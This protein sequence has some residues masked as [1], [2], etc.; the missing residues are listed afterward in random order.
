[1][2]SLTRMRLL[3]SI[4]KLAAP[5]GLLLGLGVGCR[6]A[7]E[8]TAAPSSTN[9]A[10][11]E[12][13]SSAPSFLARVGDELITESD[14]LTEFKRRLASGRPAGTASNALQEVIQRAALLQR[15]WESDVA[16]R[17][18]VLREMDN[19]LLS[20]WMD[21]TLHAE[22][23]ALAPTDADLRQAYE[24]NMGALSQPAQIRLAW[25]QRKTERSSSEET[26]ASLRSELEKARAEFLA[27]AQTRPDALRTQGFGPLA[28]DVSEDA[29]S[30]YRGGDLGWMD[31]AHPPARIPAPVIAAALALEVSGV[32]PVLE[33]EAGVYVA[34]KIDARPAQVPRYE[35]SLPGLRRRLLRAREEALEADFRSRAVQGRR[36]EID[37]ARLAALTPPAAMPAARPPSSPGPLAPPPSTA[38]SPR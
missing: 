35:D 32:T 26:R 28:A 36:V 22:K 9:A 34:A 7:P 30:R 21:E 15:A 8:P 29:A 4:L 5:V 33:D 6:K 23:A 17:P 24:A 1:M 38:A 11:V 3:S 12:T 16:L 2:D 18:D 37:Q 14:V 19:V 20:R 27:A 13:E 31:P 10:A 25:L